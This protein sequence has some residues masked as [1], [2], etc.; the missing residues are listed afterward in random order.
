MIQIAFQEV[1]DGL[2]ARKTYT[3]Q[4]TAQEGLVEASRDYYR[5]AERRY[6]TGVDS[7]LTFLDAQRS[8]FTAE[9]ALIS[10]RLAQLQDE[11]DL[12]KALRGGWSG[13]SGSSSTY[14]EDAS[15]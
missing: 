2:A 3:D 10:D 13:E 4:M 9:Q 6:R 12:Y 1:A 7:N 15:N 8:L 14:S 5:L 11:V